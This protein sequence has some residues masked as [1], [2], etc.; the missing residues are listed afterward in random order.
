MSD[1]RM[2][3][4]PP[5]KSSLQ[6]A[7]FFGGKMVNSTSTVINITS[8]RNVFPHSFSPLIRCLGKRTSSTHGRESGRTSLPCV[9]VYSQTN[10]DSSR[11]I[12]LAHALQCLTNQFLVGSLSR[13]GVGFW[14]GTDAINFCSKLGS[15]QNIFSQHIAIFYLLLTNP[16]RPLIQRCQ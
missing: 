10:Y 9:R 1:L 14:S 16:S 8:N 3:S 7:L 5:T 4:A 11:V 6:E 12:I 13:L 2:P 15:C